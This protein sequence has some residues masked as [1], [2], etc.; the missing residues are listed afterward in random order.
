MKNL[1]KLEELLLFFLSIYLFSTLDYAWWWF[2]VLLLAPDL[3]MLG[4]L[5]N[6]QTGAMAYNIAHH[7][8]IAVAVFMGGAI[9]GIQVV[10]LIGLIMLGHSSLDRVFGYGLKFPDSFQHTHLGMIGKESK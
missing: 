4:Y 3:S 6:S 10:Q 1:I 5:H 9:L 8:A 7:K 2:L